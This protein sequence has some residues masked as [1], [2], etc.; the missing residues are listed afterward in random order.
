[1]SLFK[2]TPCE[3]KFT[4]KRSL[5]RHKRKYCPYGD[6]EL[7]DSES[8]KEVF[9]CPVLGCCKQFSGWRCFFKHIN[10]CL[11]QR[12]DSTKCFRPKK[13]YVERRS[14]YEFKCPLSPCKRSFTNKDS[15]DLHKKK[16]EMIGGDYRCG[17][18]D[19]RFR[20]KIDIDHHICE[21]RKITHVSCPNPWCKQ[22]EERQHLKKHLLTCDK[23][24]YCERCKQYVL[25]KGQRKKDRIHECRR[26]LEE[27]TIESRWRRSKT[28]IDMP[29][30]VLTKELY[31]TPG[32]FERVGEEMMNTNW[33]TKN[34][35]DWQ[36]VVE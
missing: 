10:Q 17:L 33:L 5:V 24:A 19:E 20:Y 1:M 16:C 36:F 6:K 28:K 15:L 9:D 32:F 22:T 35:N 14:D 29:R 27:N 4:E 25:F 11:R 30:F 23:R 7:V 26:C 13:M 31:R 18:C 8:V 21:I 34:S 12:I 2:C 3:K